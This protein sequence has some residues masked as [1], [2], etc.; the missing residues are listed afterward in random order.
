MPRSGAGRSWWS[1]NESMSIDGGGRKL[2]MKQFVIDM[3]RQ[4]RQLVLYG[5]FGVMNTVVAYGL[6]AGL[7]FLTDSHRVALVFG[8]IFSVL[9]NF[10]S[11]GRYVFGNRSFRALLPFIASYAVTLGI[12][13]AL[14]EVLV[15]AGLNP[16]LAQAVCLPVVVILGYLINSRIVFR[17]KTA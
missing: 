15:R 17:S 14:L 5:I 7:F 2:A 8:T 1:A 16:L 10:F 11:T 6:F 4:H 13:F 9:F 12:N 3:F